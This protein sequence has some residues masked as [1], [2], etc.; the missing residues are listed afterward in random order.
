MRQIDDRH[1]EQKSC[2]EIQDVKSQL[3][4]RRGLTPLQLASR[5]A[6]SMFTSTLNYSAQPIT[7]SSS[8]C[9]EQGTATVP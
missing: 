2:V 5:T 4:D 9:S 7:R 6:E 3:I 8:A 1:R